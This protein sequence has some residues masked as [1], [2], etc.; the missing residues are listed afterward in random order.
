MTAIWHWWHWASLQPHFL[1]TLRLQQLSNGWI[2]AA[3]HLLGITMLPCPLFI[4]S[5]KERIDGWRLLNGNRLRSP[6]ENMLVTLDPDRF[7]RLLPFPSLG[8][9][10]LSLSDWR[11]SELW[12]TVGWE[13]CCPPQVFL[14]LS[15]LLVLRKRPP[16]PLGRRIAWRWRDKCKYGC[17]RKSQ[18]EIITMIRKNEIKKRKG[19]PCIKISTFLVLSFCAFVES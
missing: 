7:D 18:L 13:R 15:D 8:E 14:L 1:Q 10:K 19:L 17:R 16:Q 9:V 3:I 4:I 6:L 2:A 5:E 11:T 12:D